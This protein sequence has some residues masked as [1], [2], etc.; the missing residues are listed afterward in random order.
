MNTAII[1][2]FRFADKGALE[3]DV[4]S[5]K[6]NKIIEPTFT[7]GSLVKFLLPSLVGIFLFMVP[8]PHK[9]GVTIPV[10]MIAKMIE[11]FLGSSLPVIVCILILLSALLTAYAVLLQPFWVRESPFL[12]KLLDVGYHWMIVRMGAALVTLA[13]VFDFGPEFIK[14]AN[15]GGF[16]LKELQPLLFCVFLIAGF[17]LP[18]LFNFGLIEFFGILVAKFMR[19]IFTL[20]GRSSIDC[21]ASWV[22]DGTIGVLLTSKQY[23]EGYYTKRE[24]VVIGTTFSLVSLTFSMVVLS[25]VGLGHMFPQYYLTV[26]LA[27]LAAAIICPRIYPLSKIEDVY[28]DGSE[29]RGDREGIENGKSRFN[30]A[31]ELG[32]KRANI[33]KNT[34]KNTVVEGLENVLDMWLGVLPVVLFFGTI[35]LIIAEYSSL[36]KYLGMPFLP[37]LQLMNVPEAESVSETII[38]GFSDM[39]L[40]SVMAASF[41][42]E[43]ARF[44]VAALS[45]SQLLYMSEVGSL[46]MG[47]KIP[48]GFKGIFIIFLQRTLITLPVIV[49]CAH[50]IF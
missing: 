37:L 43:F 8:L 41:E 26:T 31:L 21:L 15:T 28:F 49:G 46:L 4:N 1:F 32:L 33:Q 19:P 38:L 14:S 40:P 20:P 7:P 30:H 10:A 22:G 2:K 50:L 48:I 29:K 13:V 12:L 6:N 25:Q 24:A 34:I 11:G 35:A 27:G 47:S 5:N 17:L 39:F 18:L 45:V 23:E 42:S 3:E 16:I 36:F 9:N 44:V